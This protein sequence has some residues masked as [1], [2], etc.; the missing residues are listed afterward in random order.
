MTDHKLAKSVSLGPEQLG[1]VS[2]AFDGA[3]EVVKVDYGDNPVSIDVG[4][5]RLASALLKAFKDGVQ[6]TNALKTAGI[7]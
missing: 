3:W 1:I 2:A 6:D 4:R 7:E 5:H